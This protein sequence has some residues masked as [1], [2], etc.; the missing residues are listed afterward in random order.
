MAYIWYIQGTFYRRILNRENPKTSIKPS[1]SAYFSKNYVGSNFQKFK[2]RAIKQ[3]KTEQTKVIKI[4]QI[5]II[6]AANIRFII[7]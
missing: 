4:I 3:N 7:Q 5:S 2:I 6:C 1:I